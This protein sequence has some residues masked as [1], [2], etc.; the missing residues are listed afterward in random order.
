MQM[1]DLS[2]LYVTLQGQKY[3]NLPVSV[4]AMTVG[5]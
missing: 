1:Q 5:S 2:L 3:T 4:A